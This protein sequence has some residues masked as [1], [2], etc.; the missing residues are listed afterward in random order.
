MKSLLIRLFEAF[1][2]KPAPLPREVTERPTP[3][4]RYLIFEPGFD[5]N[6]Q[7]ANRSEHWDA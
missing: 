7:L 4:Y 5:V 1:E 2:P 3:G 6:R